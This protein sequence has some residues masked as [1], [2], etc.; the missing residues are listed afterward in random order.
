MPM[1][2][3]RSGSTRDLLKNSWRSSSTVGNLAG[4]RRGV[5]EILARSSSLIAD[6]SVSLVACGIA[7]LV[8]RNLADR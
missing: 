1:I 6:G 3:W 4:D 2:Y 5:P 8:S 7:S